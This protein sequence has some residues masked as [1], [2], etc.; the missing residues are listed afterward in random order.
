MGRAAVSAAAQ[1]RL[2]YPGQPGPQFRA[3]LGVRRLERAE[4]EPEG[5]PAT[6]E[7]SLSSEEPIERMDWW[8]GA[9]YREVLDHSP[10][11]VRMGRFASGRA[12]F[13]E[14]HSP[15]AVGVIRRARIDPDRVLRIDVQFSA[16]QRGQDCEM[17]VRDQVRTSTSVGYDPISAILVERDEVKGDLWRVVDWEPLEGSLVSVPADATV[18]AGRDRSEQAWHPVEVSDATA[19]AKE[20]TMLGRNRLF[21]PDGGGGGAPAPAAA[22]AGPTPATRAGAVS[23]VADP[24]DG[25]QLSREQFIVAIGRANGLLA[26]PKDPSR[27]ATPGG[28]R[29]VQEMIMDGTPARA[30]LEKVLEFRRTAGTAQP[31]AENLEALGFDPEALR[32]YSIGRA[33]RMAV[34]LALDARGAAADRAATPHERPAGL[35][36]DVHRELEK[37]YPA[38]AARHG[39]ILVPL[40]MPERFRPRGAQRSLTGVAKGAGAELVAEQRGDLIEILRN[41]TAVLRRGARYLTGLTAPIAFPKQVA[42]MV[43]QWIGEGPLSDVSDSDL[44]LGLALLEPKTLMASTSYSRQLLAQSSID[45]DALISDDFG[46]VHA[47]A[48]DKSALVGLGAAGEPAGVYKQTGVGIKAVGGAQSYATLVDMQTAVVKA[49]ALLGTLGWIMPPDMA[50]NLRKILDFPASSAGRPVWTGTYAEGEVAGYPASA[51]NQ[52][53]ITMTGSE[54]TG[55]SE[56]GSVFGNWADMIIGGFG[57]M[58]I[59]VDPFS[60]KKR[61]LVELTS[62]QMADVLCRHGESFCKSTGATG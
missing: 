4:G 29:L 3:G 35:E 31:G 10:G 47:I 60:K 48:L 53:P 9:R 32:G 11:C 37:L 19:T 33:I 17:D 28:E 18:G 13:L 34:G 41:Y 24:A 56:M 20:E 58:E 44:A 38:N 55:G 6:Y 46:A 8:T 49:N 51:T 36:W 21:N 54:R 1:A 2:R 22:E 52:M 15:P 50:G 39:G 16:T 23:A 40:R 42:A 7:F 57:A 45:V 62:F 30:V 14:E 12:N 26:D 27:R 25:E 59:V 61:A 5:A 43:A